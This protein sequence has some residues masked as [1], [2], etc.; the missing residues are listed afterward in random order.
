MATIPR[1]SRRNRKVREADMEVACTRVTLEKPKRIVGDLP[2]KLD[3]S[4]ARISKIGKT[5]DKIEWLL[6]TNTEIGRAE[7]CMGI[8]GYSVRRWP[9][10][11]FHFVLKSGYRVER[12]Q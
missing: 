12:I 11:R 10:A 8:V 4:L 2:G 3:M 9:I 6:A 1:V 5:A 7:D